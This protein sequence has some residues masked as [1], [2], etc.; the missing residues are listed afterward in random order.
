MCKCDIKRKL[1]GGLVLAVLYCAMDMFFHH[2][3]MGSFYERTM[4]LWR[5]MEETRGLMGFAYVGYLLFGFIFY[6]VY[7]F[8]FEADKAK[9][10][11]GLKYGIIV[12]VLIKGAG[13]L[14]MFPFVPYPGK[15]IFDWFLIGLVEYALLGIVTGLLFKP[16]A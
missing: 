4:N 10:I 13:G 16:K 2:V 11:Q 14:L 7:G 1:V 6:C 12:A 15:L 5:P 3:C 8:G 9:W